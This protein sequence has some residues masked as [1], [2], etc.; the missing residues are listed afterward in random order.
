MLVIQLTLYCLLFTGMVR[1]AVRGGA[2]DGLFFYPKAV[3]KRA[4]EIGLITPEKM[5]KKRKIFMTEFYIVM[6]VAL[7]LIVG[8]WNHIADFKSAYLEALLFLEVM[9]IYD[10]VVIDK[11]WV[12]YSKFWKLPGCE[13]IPYMQTWLQV[14]KKRSFLAVIWVVGAAIVAGIIVLIFGLAWEIL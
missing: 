1:Y 14:L 11:L 8:A 3:Q 12:G 13:D 9:N 4:F 2:I 7:V 6:L 10:G 5:K